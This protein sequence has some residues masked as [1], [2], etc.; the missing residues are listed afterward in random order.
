MGR[1]PVDRPSGV[2][3][4]GNSVR[5][6]FTWN[7]ERRCETLAYPPTPQGIAAAGGLRA[8]VKQLIKLGVLDDDKYAELF[9]TSSYSLD[10]KTPSFGEYAQTWLDSREI[11][12]STR[13]NYKATL[14]RYWMP[15]FATRRLDTIKS[16]EIRRI[17]ATTDWPS[18]GVR[19]NAIDKGSSIFKSAVADGYIDRNPFAGIARPKLQKRLIDPFERDEAE[20]I[21][22]TMY[23]TLDGLLAVYAAYFEFAFFTG[24]RPS[25][26]TAL[27][28]SD[29]DMRKRT[30]HVGKVR[31]HGEIHQRVKTKRDRTVLLNDRAIHA[32]EV[33]EP[34]TKE[35]S[36]HV[37]APADNSGPYIRSDNTTKKYL[38][39]TLAVL[40]I[41]RRRQYDTRHTYATMCIMAGMNPAFIANQLGHS[42]QM[43]LSTYAKWLNSTSDWA[44]I[45]KLESSPANG[46]KVV[47]A[48]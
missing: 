27:K 40:K 43:L 16:G 23:E 25:E 32:L 47:Q 14:N 20:L 28:W 31:V 35:R 9:P 37:F 2:E 10:H 46:M 15:H 39:Q 18:P 45:G 48:K 4:V 36:E 21:I 26:M 29:V 24:M 7:G 34:L 22:R 1:K 19:R 41:R 12:D 33:V 6:R 3:V 13:R 8:Q 11:V 17:I 38:L 42:V 44:E 5:I 30:A